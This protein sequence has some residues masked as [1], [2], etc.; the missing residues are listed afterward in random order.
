MSNTRGHQC[1]RLFYLE[2]SDSVDDAPQDSAVHEENPPLI[3]LQAITGIRTEDTMQVQVTIGNRSFT[4]LMDSGSC[5][6]FVSCTAAHHVGLKLASTNGA[7][8]VV[9]NGNRVECCGLARDVNIKIGAE[10][11]T[12]DCYSMP[13]DSFDMIMGVSFLKKFGPILWDLNDLSMLFWRHDKRVQ[14]NGVRPHHWNTSPTYHLS[15]VH[16]HAPPLRSALS[17]PVDIQYLSKLEL[18][19]AFHQVMFASTEAKTDRT[20]H[21]DNIL[22][23]GLSIASVVFHKSLHFPMTNV[24]AKLDH[25]EATADPTNISYDS[26]SSFQLEDQ[27][28]FKEGRNVMHAKASSGS[29]GNRTGA[30]RSATSC[31]RGRERELEGAHE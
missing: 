21:G 3:S 27:L 1:S 18:L 26:R 30:S 15:S 25:A 4:A 2:V 6:N 24:L 11:F 5:T 10:M 23:F 29:S 8:A 9:A 28:H 20:A 19:H 13:L 16:G 14:W 7:R 31:E 17:L 12:I 22:P